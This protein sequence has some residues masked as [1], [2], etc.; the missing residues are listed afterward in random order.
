MCVIY[1]VIVS[2]RRLLKPRQ[3]IVVWLIGSNPLGD[4]DEKLHAMMIYH[5]TKFHYE[6]LSGSEDTV[7]TNIPGGFEPSL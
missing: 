4:R 1:K 6:R 7:R 3:A 5:H 2:I